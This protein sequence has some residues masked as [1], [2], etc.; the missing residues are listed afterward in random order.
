VPSY[1]TLAD[2]YALG[3][4]A[5][6][7][8]AIP[9]AIES[10]DKD[11]GILTLTGN[12][13]ANG[14]FL[15]FVVE[16]AATLGKPD[17][18]LPQGLSPVVM[19]TAAPLNGSS[20]LFRVAPDGGSVVTSFG[21]DGS[22]VFSIIV[23]PAQTIESI[24]ADESAQVDN[25]L[26][27]Q[28]PPILPD[29]VTHL[30]PQILVGVVAR[31]AAVRAALSLGLANPIYQASLDRLVA[32]QAFD[33]ARLEEWLNGREIKPDV[34]DQTTYADDAARARSGAWTGRCFTPWIRQTL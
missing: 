22:G 5:Q 12:G 25:C 14:T 7:F 18:A 21:D 13:L 19:Y 33:N 10:V 30:Y 6:A 1:A 4:R 17:A 9:R 26:T 29:P 27:G 24:I 34:L 32:G 15:R 16:G 28:A 2:V 8:A 23:D 3:L 11:T 20:D 31:R